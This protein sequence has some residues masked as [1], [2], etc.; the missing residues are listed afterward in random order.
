MTT[1]PPPEGRKASPQFVDFLNRW[2]QQEADLVAGKVLPTYRDRRAGHSPFQG[3]ALIDFRQ[4]VDIEL[5]RDQLPDD[6][7]EAMTHARAVPSATAIWEAAKL[8]D[9]D[10]RE[11]LVYHA[12]LRAHRPAVVELVAAALR[13]NPR[14]NP[15]GWYQALALAVGLLHSGTNESDSEELEVTD[16]EEARETGFERLGR[17]VAIESDYMRALAHIDAPPEESAMAGALSAMKA[18]QEQKTEAD[19]GGHVVAEI[20]DIVQ[21]MLEDRAEIR[22]DPTLK[23]IDA[24]PNAK[25]P[26][27]RADVW[28]AYK[29]V[30]GTPLRLVSTSAVPAARTDL[31]ARY[32]HMHAEIDAILSTQAALQ[33]V[34]LMVLLVGKPGTGKTTFAREL[35]DRL[36]VPAMT[37]S[38]AGASD[39][40]FGGTSAQWNSARPATPLQLVGRS[41]TANPLVVLDEVDKIG[42]SKHNGSLSDTLL[43]F[44]EPASSRVFFDLALEVPADLSAVSYI[45]T[46]NSLEDVPTPLRD[47]FKVVRIPEPGFEHIGVLTGRILDDLARERGL[48]RRWM[49]PLAQDEEDLVH[50][51]WDG[52]SLRKLTRIITMIVDGREKLMARA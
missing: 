37:Y 6:L 28:K 19:P 23:V 8:A 10:L 52:G 12:A 21:A 4:L 16:C 7:V 44:L 17:L 13:E 42:T 3:S 31:H 29:P 34:R 18:A 9:A 49:E 11:A 43:T 50:K 20:G 35:T 38:C 5:E 2:R 47:R 24:D 30:I 40:A 32:P 1:N 36:G 22:R 48:D 14:Y 51:A 46:A 45:A 15:V 26:Q 41:K 25:Q 33:S 27:S 39:G